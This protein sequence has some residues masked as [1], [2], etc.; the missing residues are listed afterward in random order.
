MVAHHKL[1][2]LKLNFWMQVESSVTG[3]LVPGLGGHQLALRCA[4][5]SARPPPSSPSELCPKLEW[6]VEG[7]GLTCRTALLELDR[8]CAC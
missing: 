5:A 7:E 8:R 3:G 2:R 4:I 1:R 6:Y